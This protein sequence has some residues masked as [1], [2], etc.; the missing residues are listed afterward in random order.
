MSNTKAPTIIM[1]SWMRE[2]LDLTGIEL[3]IFSYIFDRTFDKVHKC[4]TCL[5]DMESWFG[6]TRQ[7]ISRNMEKLVQKKYIYKF[8][9]K[10]SQ[11]EFIKHNCYFVNIDY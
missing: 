6:V 4:W 11:K 1:W 3:T 10:D 2:V 8:S 7:T 9:Q 5:S